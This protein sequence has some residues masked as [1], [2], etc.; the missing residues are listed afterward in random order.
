M[1]YWLMKSEPETYGID[2]L[3][4]DRVTPWEGVR[5][6]SA[7]NHMRA[8][9]KGDLIL[10]YH[11]SADEIGVAGIGKIVAEA[12]PDESQ[13]KRGGDY[14]E[15]RATREKPVWYCVDVGFHERFVHLVTLAEIKADPT[16]EGMLVRERGSRLSVQP[17]SEKH[18]V[19]IREMAAK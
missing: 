12:H 2:H 11:S 6:F 18:F 5:N 13:Y 3:K 8:M 16:L 15:P 14:F 9:K 17:V 19:H 1:Q 4:R 10:F 7:R